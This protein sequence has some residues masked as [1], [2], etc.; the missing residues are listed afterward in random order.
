MDNSSGA[1]SSPLAVHLRPMTLADLPSVLRIEQAVQSHPWRESHFVNCLQQSGFAL[2]AVNEANLVGYGLVSQGGGEADLLNLAVVAECQGRGV[3]TQLLRRLISH[4]ATVADTLFLEVRE[5]N[6][7]AQALYEKM[8]F[9]QVGERPN[10][11]PAQR[12]R[13]AAFI[14]ALSLMS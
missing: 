11:Y 9:N 4:A 12:G 3:A 5:S 8:G 6:G 14:Y 10:Y 2:V 13:E 7:S 1:A